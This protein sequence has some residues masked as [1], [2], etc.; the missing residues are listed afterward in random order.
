MM[1]SVNFIAQL[2]EYADKERL[3]VKYEDVDSVGPDHI[4][5]FTLRAV[6]NGKAYP[7]GVGKNKKEAK[8]NAAK[9]ALESLSKEPAVST[10]KGTEVFPARVQLKSTN[11]TCWLNEYG[12]KNRVSVRTVETTRLG[13]SSASQ[14]C[15]FVVGDKEYQAA[16]G[17]TKKEAKEEAAKLVYH[18][19][20]GGETTRTEDGRDSGTSSLQKE[21]LDEILLDICDKTKSLSIQ[22]EDSSPAETNFV[23]IVNQYCQKQ[24]QL[25]AFV[26]DRRCGLSH[27]PT[28]FY[29]LVIDKKE[30]PVGE[31]KSI[32]E[33]KQNAAQLAWSAL[34]E[35]PDWDSKVC[36][37][38]HAKQSPSTSTQDSGH[39]KSSS[40]T[41]TSTPAVITPSS[42]HPAPGTNVKP[43]IRIAAN[44]QNACDKSKE[45]MINFKVKSK[46]NTQTEKTPTQSMM[47]RFTLDYDSIE[48][49]DK[50]SFGYVFKAKHKLEEKYYAVKIVRCKDN[51]KNALPE[52]K[53]LSDLNHCNIVR[54]H[55]CWM[56]ESGY[57]WDSSTDSSSA[58]QSS[59]DS[60]A[61]YLYIQMELCSIKT[62]RV[63]IDEKNVQNPK[64]SLRDS[65]RRK[66]SLTIAL[67]IVSGVDY[68]HSKRL[69]HRDLKPANIMFGQSGSVKIGD[70]GLVTE[71]IEN[72]SENQ[73]ERNKYKGT[74]SY[75]APEQREKTLYI[76]K[77][78]IFALGLIYFELLWNI[79]TIDD[80]T[81]IW[82]DVRKRKFPQGFCQHHLQESEMIQSMLSEKPEERP[83]ASKLKTDLEHSLEIL[84]TMQLDSKTTFKRQLNRNRSRTSADNGVEIRCTEKTEQCFEF[85]TYF[86]KAY[87][88][89]LL[90][91]RCVI[92]M[93]SGNYVA[94]ICDYAQKSGL[95]WTFEVL[96]CDG[97]DH[98]KKFFQRVVLDG[99]AYPT[100]VG[101]SKK[102][103]K[104]NAAEHAWNCLLTGEDQSTAEN[105]AEA[106]AAVYVT[107]IN[108]ICWLNQYGQRNSLKI[109]PVPTTKPGLHNATCWCKF[110]VGDKEYPEVSGKTKRDAK[111]A[112]AK[113]VYDIICGGNSTET[114]DASGP[115]N[116]K[117]DENVADICS[118][119]SSLSVNSVDNGDKETNYI[120]FINHYCQKK[121]LQPTFME[122]D[123]R[124]PPHCP[125][126]HYRWKIADKEYPVGV[127]KNKTEA[128]QN[129]AKLA[130]SAL[131]DQSDW[132]SEVSVKSTVSENGA[133][134]T[135][136]TQ[137]LNES[138]SQNFQNSASDSVVFADSSNLSNA[139]NDVQNRDIENAS[140]A[141]NRPRFTEEFHTIG[142]LGK[143]G[144]GRVYQATEKLTNLEYAVKI[145]EGIKK[146]VQE[147]RALSELQHDN[148]VRYYNCW[149]EDSEYQDDN[150]SQSTSESTSNSCPQYLYIRMELCSPKTLRNWIKEK[151]KN[152]VQ[153]S[154]RSAESL[155]IA[156][157]IVSGVKCIHSHKLIHRDLKP[158][159]IMFGKDGKVKIGDFGLVTAA[160]EGDDGNLMKRTIRKGT[161]SYMAP[162]QMS[163]EYD[164]KVDMFALGLIFFELLWKIST[165]HERAMIWRDARSKKFPEEFSKTFL[166]E[167]RIVNS[168]LSE[169]PERRPEASAVEAELKECAEKRMHLE[170]QTV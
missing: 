149:M 53:V 170:N 42:K 39:V 78:D 167:S 166:Q 71:E 38:A 17:K 55:S 65:K 77:V 21:E 141:S 157:Q 15:R 91:N 105:T 7:D 69:I 70:F 67:Q 133:P 117:L 20:V 146:A 83:E 142:G 81:E 37:G 44:F 124:G 89:V 110:V 125:E 63:W 74:P 163:Q 22:I 84:K 60:S 72:D 134:S 101:K 58:S 31:G 103:A 108:Y 97:P 106:S 107:D 76:H 98:N 79:P 120:G 113:L 9:N 29:K 27:T 52:V 90:H 131:Q 8:Q 54:Y 160:T 45:D 49:L 162:E 99:K 145:V 26:E 30:Y 24:K 119:T 138:S 43:K 47:S 130:W 87:I 6:L 34:K 12:Q 161:I 80:K 121:N 36:D 150:L 165:G 152:D 156:Q 114:A 164:H 158:A 100:G 1:E 169:K 66:E 111:E 155:P 25:C 139:Q 2:K 153:G 68:I 128:K 143:G 102:D 95:L 23:G 112:A 118:R 136:S 57:Q 19:I 3:V 73:K 96:D 41:S 144:Y 46:G 154:Q 61:K 64:K 40:I 116:E 50:G 35:Q 11:Y 126:F 86:Y 92:A 93:A 88:C 85:C 62:L 129:A 28:F 75:M 10:E 147:A 5:T 104:Q 135:M 33:A 14:W 115:Q 109:K 18:E 132:D 13:P 123:K 94:K 32:K 16:S 168:L 4:K 51:V 82:A 122:V 127:G 159:N 151:N 56:E 137:D 59:S 48:R 140:G 148:I